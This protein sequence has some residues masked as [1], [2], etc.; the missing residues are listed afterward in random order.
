METEVC[1]EVGCHRAGFARASWCLGPTDTASDRFPAGTPDAV[2]RTGPR[3]ATVMVARRWKS[4]TERPDIGPQS[5]R[6]LMPS[7]LSA[8]GGSES[9]VQRA[10]ATDVASSRASAA[11]ALTFRP[12]RVM[13]RPPRWAGWFMAGSTLPAGYRPSA[14][15]SRRE[16]IPPSGT[17][18]LTS[19]RSPYSKEDLEGSDPARRV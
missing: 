1:R 9:S 5:L 19:W 17:E 12:L 2:S 7:F 6:R 14:D 13:R 16:S 10:T 3:C 4:P 11:A 8:C 15:H 18:D